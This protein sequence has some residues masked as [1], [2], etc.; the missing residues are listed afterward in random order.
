VIKK[1]ASLKISFLRINSFSLDIGETASIMNFE[2]SLGPDFELYVHT[3]NPEQ[4]LSEHIGF[5][6]ISLQDLENRKNRKSPQFRWRLTQLGIDK[7]CVSQTHKILDRKYNTDY[8][9]GTREE[10]QNQAFIVSP[11]F[12]DSGDHPTDEGHL[13]GGSGKRAF[14]HYYSTR[15][16]YDKVKI[17]DLEKISYSLHDPINANKLVRIMP[18]CIGLD[19][20]VCE[21]VESGLG[22]RACSDFDFDHPNNKNFGRKL[23]SSTVIV[24]LRLHFTP[25][26]FLAHNFCPSSPI[27]PCNTDIMSSGPQGVSV[28]H[29]ICHKNGSN[30]RVFEASVLKPEME[31]FRQVSLEKLFIS[32]TGLYGHDLSQEFMEYRPL[33]S[34][35]RDADWILFPQQTRERCYGPTKLC[36][37]KDSS[38]IVH[39]L[40][41]HFASNGKFQD[42]ITTSN[43]RMITWKV[44]KNGRL[45]LTG[46]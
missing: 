43:G 31:P 42:Y 35:E 32:D 19:F 20:G 8:A 22:L 12:S 34:S 6:Q 5:L 28:K 21:L 30:T 38:D 18:G 1:I 3:L 39:L 10:M 7:I 37:I 44:N 15:Y 36:I 25:L 24:N 45:N 29:L 14:V 2:Q 4:S 17:G 46:K 41:H 9:I 13:L 23:I 27:W 40:N 11:S 16:Y 26:G 33:I